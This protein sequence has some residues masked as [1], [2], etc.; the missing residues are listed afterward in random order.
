MQV[1]QTEEEPPNHGRIILE[2]SGC[3]RNNKQALIKI[4]IPKRERNR[5]KRRRAAVLPASNES[6]AK[7][8]TSGFHLTPYD[9]L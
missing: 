1:I 4:V 6:A 2:A 3:T 7:V 8:D 9:S 5:R